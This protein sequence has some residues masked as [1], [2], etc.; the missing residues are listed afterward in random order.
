[1][2]RR[3]RVREHT[4]I[5]DVKSMNSK[6]KYPVKVKEHTRGH[7]DPRENARGKRSTNELIN[8]SRLADETLEDTMV[9]SA[10]EAYNKA[11]ERGLSYKAALEEA[12]YAILGFSEEHHF[13][14]DEEINNSQRDSFEEYTMSMVH[15]LA[16]EAAPGRPGRT[17]RV[18]DRKTG[19]WDEWHSEADAIASVE[20]RNESAHA[21]RFFVEDGVDE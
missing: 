10:A 1:M 9:I 14:D 7:G 19:E 16:Q 15:E 3:H 12:E 11:R 2:V 4:R 8:V 20:R 6:I 5:T 17:W 21:S 18:V 13:A